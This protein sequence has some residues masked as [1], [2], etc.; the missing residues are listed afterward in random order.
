MKVFLILF[1]SF[2]FVNAAPRV[3]QPRTPA[4]FYAIL[5]P[6]ND[7]LESKLDLFSFGID[8][9]N[10]MALLHIYQHLNP[11]KLINLPIDFGK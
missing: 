4:R 6:S 5:Q 10:E 9:L 3:L 2:L 7:Y 11:D 8:H 1:S